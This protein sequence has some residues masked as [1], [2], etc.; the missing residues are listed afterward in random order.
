LKIIVAAVIVALGLA[1]GGFL[2][3]GRYVFMAEDANAVTRLDR[4]T[5]A[6]EMCIVGIGPGKDACGFI[7]PPAK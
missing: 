5:G 2:I 6:V 3:G 7:G 1:A 4:F